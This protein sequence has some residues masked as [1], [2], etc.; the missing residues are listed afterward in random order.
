[1]VPGVARRPFFF[2]RCFFFWELGGLPVLAG[3]GR[4][5]FSCNVSPP[6]FVRPLSFFSVTLGKSPSDFPCQPG[7]RCRHLSIVILPFFTGPFPSSPR[8][9][10]PLPFFLREDSE[11]FFCLGDFAVVRKFFCTDV[12]SRRRPPAFLFF[13]EILLNLSPPHSLSG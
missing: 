5:T 11:R 12:S 3:C 2:L 9:F 13:F 1:L 6:P 10:R 4:A 7:G 8:T